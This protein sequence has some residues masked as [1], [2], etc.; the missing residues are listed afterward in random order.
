MANFTDP[1]QLSATFEGLGPM[2]PYGPVMMH[3]FWDLIGS[4]EY[5]KRQTNFN[6]KP[7]GVDK[8]MQSHLI[9]H[10]ET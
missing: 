5:C 2:G 4:R 3:L 7:P 6:Q 10:C 1:I 9:S 8:D